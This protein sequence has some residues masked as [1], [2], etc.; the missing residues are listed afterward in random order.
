MQ[1]VECIDMLYYI[2]NLSD[3]IGMLIGFVD[4]DW[5]MFGMYGGELIIVVGCLLMGK[6]VFLMNIGEYVVVEYGLL[7]VVFLM[8]MLGIQFVMCMF[9]LIGWFDQYWMCMGCLMDEDWL[10]LMYV[11]QKMSEVQFFIDEMGGLNLME[12]CLCVWCLVW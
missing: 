1:V 10:K 2:V 7:V 11:V 6:I 9:G 5:M 4:F 12:L 8:E 3:V